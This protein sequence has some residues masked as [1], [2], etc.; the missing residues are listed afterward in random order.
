MSCTYDTL[1]GETSLQ[2]CLSS[3][4]W[5][6]VMA[7]DIGFERH[8]RPL[9]L[10]KFLTWQP[11]IYQLISKIPFFPQWGKKGKFSLFKMAVHN[12][13]ME[14][15][16]VSRFGKMD[17]GPHACLNKKVFKPSSR[18][19]SQGSMILKTGRELSL[20]NVMDRQESLKA[21]RG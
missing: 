14:H 11:W 13:S 1:H 19:S 16:R 6:S 4:I 5:H 3:T 18:S 15:K 7:N 20:V 12:L 9:L 8:F 2:H 21:P 17:G 10:R